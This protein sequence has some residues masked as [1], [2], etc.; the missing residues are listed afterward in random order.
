LLLFRWKILTANQHTIPSGH[1]VIT[2]Q[3]EK[4]SVGFGFVERYN[5]FFYR[6]VTNERLSRTKT[7]TMKETGLMAMWFVD[8][9]LSID[10]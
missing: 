7:R 3:R 4:Q 5:R 6:S 2:R 8:A 9:T 1:Y 10:K